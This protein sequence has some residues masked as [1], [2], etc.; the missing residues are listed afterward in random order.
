MA[1]TPAAI[2]IDH[3]VQARF[4]VKQMLRPT[5]FTFAGESD[6]GQEAITLATDTRPDVMIIALNT[7]MERPLQTI[8]SLLGLF[9]ETPVIAYSQS[10]DIDA[11]R[12]AMLAGVRDF[13]PLPLKPDTLRES[14]VRS[15]AA[16][17]NRRLRHQ[18]HVSGPT[19]LGT[20]ITVFGAKGGIGKSTIS[21]NLAVSL[22]KHGTSTVIVDLDTGFGDV[23]SMLDVRPERTLGDLARDVDHVGREELRDYVAT[24]VAS[25]LDIVASPP[26][27][28]WRQLSVDDLRQSIE[29]LSKY[30]DKI[31]LDTSGS[32]NEVSELALELATIVLWVTTTEFTSVRDSLEAMRAMETLAL[33]KERMRVVLN[34]VSP[35]DNVRPKTLQDVFQKDVFWQIPYDKR[36]RQG[37]HFGQPIAVSQPQS[38]AA[39]SIADLATVLAGGRPD[40]GRKPSNGVKFAGRTR[41]AN[42][43][44]S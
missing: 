36:V 38:A 41:A 13:L 6:F 21:T 30:Y 31:V 19:A 25:G 1:R 35:E 3:D 5:G 16:E 28:E 34:T 20:V 12:A 40:N 11:V 4:E 44:G 17:E 42:A 37:T 24:H 8:E 18:G 2:I 23:T 29:L 15:M 14:I 32:L 26:V 39:R 27:L 22:A 9:P 43:E 7:P 33:P 10:R